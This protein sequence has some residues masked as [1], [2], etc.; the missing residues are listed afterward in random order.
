MTTFRHFLEGL[1]NDFIIQLIKKLVSG[2]TRLYMQ[3]IHPEGFYDAEGFI[4]EVSVTKTGNLFIEFRTWSSDEGT[5]V[6]SSVIV[7]EEDISKLIIAI[8]DRRKTLMF[9]R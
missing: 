5:Y 9:E 2:P 1:G 8:Y 4:E 3:L 7:D 6:P